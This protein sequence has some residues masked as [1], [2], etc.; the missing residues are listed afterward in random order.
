MILAVDRKALQEA[1]ES[2]PRLATVDGFT[3]ELAD[4]SLLFEM[5]EFS[6][7]LEPT[8]TETGNLQIA[9]VAKGD[10]SSEFCHEKAQVRQLKP[11]LLCTPSGDRQGM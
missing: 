7:T 10:N 1:S 8:L 5:V 6:C 4:F 9:I 2:N 3:E 11:S